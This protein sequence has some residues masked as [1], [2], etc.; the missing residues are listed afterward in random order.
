MHD[1]RHLQIGSSAVLLLGFLGTP[2]CTPPTARAKATEPAPTLTV[3]YVRLQSAAGAGDVELPGTLVSTSTAVLRAPIAGQVAELAEEGSQLRS[4]QTAA[5][6]TAT[7]LPATVD[8]TAAALE[9]AVRRQSGA[10]TAVEQAVRLKSTSAAELEQNLKSAEADR[11]RRKALL[12]E[13]RHQLTTEPA[14]LKAAVQAAEARVRLLKSGERIQRLRQLQAE[15]DVAKSEVSVAESQARRVKELYAA[16]LAARRELEVA[17]LTVRRA[18]SKVVQLDEELKLQQEGAHPEAIK[19]AEEQVEVARQSLRAA[20][21]L[22]E[23]LSQRKAELA[24]AEAEVTRVKQKLEAVQL[25]ELP[26]DRARKDAQASA[27]ETR[28]LRAELAEARDRLGR[29]TLSA[30]F[31]GQVVRRHAQPGETV[32]Q[33][34]SLL[35]VVDP[36]RLQFQ[37]AVTESDLGRLRKGTPVELAL[38]AISP[39]PL[40]GRVAEIIEAS[41]PARGTYQVRI[42]VPR[43]AEM[44]PGMAGTARVRGPREQAAE[45]RI[46]LSALRKHFPRENRGEVWVL[47]GDRLSTRIAVLGPM[48]SDRVRIV[49]GLQRG[50]QVV[51]SDLNGDLPQGEVTGREVALP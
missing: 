30:P 8:A 13:T 17:A 28:R 12:A 21:A 35:E 34:A 11:D 48:V 19:E 2:G 25:D 51:V 10:E 1:P 7:G 41:G 45:I 46:P 20:D 5:V 9:A 39:R 26:I 14:R 6:L 50:D 38:P 42:E 4:G 43:R 37:G 31:A 40:T 27:A 3:E 22:Q 16:G 29:S 47:E 23:Q 18:N 44:K 24:A 33:G 36:S 32:L 15:I 49:S